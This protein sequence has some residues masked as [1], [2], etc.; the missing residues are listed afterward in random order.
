MCEKEFLLENDCFYEVDYLKDGN[1]LQIIEE[2]EP[3]NG[4]EWKFGGTTSEDLTE[5]RTICICPS[6]KSEID[7]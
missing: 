6:C 1:D 3:D 7:S 2:D 4:D 5:K